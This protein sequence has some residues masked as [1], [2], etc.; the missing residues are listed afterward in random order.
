MPLAL[1]HDDVLSAEQVF[2]AGDV[3]EPG[4]VPVWPSN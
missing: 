4:G 2:K 3:F 1:W